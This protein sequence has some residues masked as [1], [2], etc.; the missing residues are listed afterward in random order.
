MI[1]QLAPE[2]K[3]EAMAAASKAGVGSKHGSGGEDQGPPG[4]R[5]RGN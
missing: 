3:R 1:G 2:A 5:S 4:K